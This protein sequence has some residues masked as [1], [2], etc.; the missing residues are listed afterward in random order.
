MWRTV[1]F[2]GRGGVADDLFRALADPTRRELLDRLRSRDGQSLKELSA[3]LGMA[4]QSVA[5]HLGILASAGLVSVVRRGR[6]RVHYLN[7]APIQEMADRWIAPFAAARAQLFTDLK[8]ALEEPPMDQPTFHYVTYIRTTPERLWRALT[9][10]VFTRRYW[11]LAME[12]DWRPGS[13]YA[14]QIGAA[15]PRIEDPEQIVIE[16]DPPRRLTYTWH[17]FTNEWAAHY[18]IPAALAGA[19]AAEPRSRVTFD[20]EPHGEKVKLTVHHE[21]FPPGSK[22]FEGISQGWPELLAELKTLLESAEGAAL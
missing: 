11:D 9:E 17:T 7:A 15:G 5:Q 8:R 12:S 3:G 20:I 14:V 18:Q 4:R 22:V 6:E 21:G 10:P 2:G 19:Y 13:T 16:A 1:A